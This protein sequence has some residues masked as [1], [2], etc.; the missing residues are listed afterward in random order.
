M[1]APTADTVSGRRGGRR[2]CPRPRAHGVCVRILTGLRHDRPFPVRPGRVREL[3][4]Q[5]EADRLQH[6][7]LRVP[8]LAATPVP[9]AWREDDDRR[10]GLE[11]GRGNGHSPATPA[12]Y[13]RSDLQEGARRRRR[14]GLQ[15]LEREAGL[16]RETGWEGPR[17]LPGHD[18]GVGPDTPRLGRHVP[19]LLHQPPEGKSRRFR[20]LRLPLATRHELALRGPGMVPRV[21]QSTRC[22]HRSLDNGKR[23]QP[24]FIHA[25]HLHCLRSQGRNLVHRGAF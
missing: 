4:R 5:H 7:S 3:S 21:C 1:P 2:R 23:L 16:F 24:Q 12:G 6:D 19:Q 22:T 17:C 20:L 10:S 25:Q 13:R 15:P 11:G 8:R 18:Q 9:E 14:V